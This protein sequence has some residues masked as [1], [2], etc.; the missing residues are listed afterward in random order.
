MN[1]KKYG[2][3][4]STKILSWGNRTLSPTPIMLKDGIIRVFCGIRDNLGVVE[5]DIDVH[6]IKKVINFSK[7]P[8]LILE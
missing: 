2:L 1:W 5:S 6:I 3:V 8:C 4:W 7:E